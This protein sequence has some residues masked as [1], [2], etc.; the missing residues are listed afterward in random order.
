MTLRIRT[1]ADDLWAVTS[2][3]NPSRFARRL[4][5]FKTFRARLNVPL[6]AVE[7]AYGSDFELDET[8]ADILVRVQGGAVLWQKERLLNLALQKLPA[9][10][11]K[12]A[13]LD[14]DIFFDSPDWG[15]SASALLDR[16]GLIQAFRNVHYLPELWMQA[17]VQTDQVNTDSV[18][19]TRPSATFSIASG[20]PATACLGHPLNEREGTSAP[21]FAWAA[22]R[23]LLDRHGFFDACILGGGDR[24]LAC[25]ANR[26]FDEL[27]ERHYMNSRQRDRYL[28]WARP[29]QE[30]VRAEVG[31][32]DH[33]IFHL[34]HGSD[35]NRATRARHE[36]LQR[37]GFDPFDDIAIDANGAW[38]WSTDKRDMHEYVRRYFESRKEDG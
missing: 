1:T 29:F 33:D 17:Q 16:F 15:A 13:W 12:V 19:F 11:R 35:L 37:F 21:G 18:D 2:Y 9:E 28:A 24:A 4:S 10:C 7:L 5:N 6:V 32:L 30:S 31:H 25:A 26:C 22:R 38:R 27:I 34:W 14:G 3:F 36:G 23:E 8:D 20:M